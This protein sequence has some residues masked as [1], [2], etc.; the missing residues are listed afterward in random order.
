MMKLVASDYLDMA[1]ALQ[2]ARVPTQLEAWTG[3]RFGQTERLISVRAAA[4]T[5]EWRARWIPFG[6]ILPA[7][8]GGAHINIRLS[9]L[10]KI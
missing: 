6:P 9:Y 3:A 1:S 2:F 7:R 8:V 4:A 5:R 10:S